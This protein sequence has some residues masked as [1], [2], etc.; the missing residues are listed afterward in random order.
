MELLMKYY[1]DTTYLL[2]L[3]GTGEE[4]L[5]SPKEDWKLENFELRRQI[6]FS[7]TCTYE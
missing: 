7:C 4:E 2:L 1:E 3:M 6:S 5:L